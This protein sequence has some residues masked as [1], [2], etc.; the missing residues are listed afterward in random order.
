MFVQ[1]GAAERAL[2]KENAPGELVKA[3]LDYCQKFETAMTR[4]RAAVQELTSHGLLGPATVSI[5]R[6][7]KTLKVEGF[8]TLSEEKL[9]ELPDEVL[10]GFMR[11]GIGTIISAHLLSLSRFATMGPVA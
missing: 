10:A 1:N 3:A 11:R 5:T 6:D 8:Q 9:R 7:G 4:T 2:F